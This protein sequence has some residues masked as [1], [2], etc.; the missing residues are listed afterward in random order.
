VS[1]QTRIVDL[2]RQLKISK[3]ALAAISGGCRNHETV[4]SEALDALWALDKKQPSAGC[5]RA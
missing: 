5:C 2:Q 1:H 4:A 3:T